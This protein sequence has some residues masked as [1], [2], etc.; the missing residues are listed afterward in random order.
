LITADHIALHV[1]L[2]FIFT[3]NASDYLFFA[4]LAFTGT[5]C[6]FGRQLRALFLRAFALSFFRRIIW[7]LEVLVLAFGGSAG[8]S[9]FV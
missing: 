7:E 1:L 2:L 9:G 4:S 8:A 3:A 5:G 6:G